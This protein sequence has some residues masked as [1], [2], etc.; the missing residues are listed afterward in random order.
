[1]TTR[2][3]RPRTLQASRTLLTITSGVILGGGVALGVAVRSADAATMLP[4]ALLRTAGNARGQAEALATMST[5][6]MVMAVL[7]GTLCL[8]LAWRGT[9]GSPLGRGAATAVLPLSLIALA[10]SSWAALLV[11]VPCLVAVAL[12]WTRSASAYVRSHRAAARG[13]RSPAHAMFNPRVPSS[14]LGQTIQ[15]PPGP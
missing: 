13:D 11:T 15:Q 8:L 2:D 7:G 6:L 1:M 14:N 3:Q 4:T 12:L 5:T 10:A 9:S